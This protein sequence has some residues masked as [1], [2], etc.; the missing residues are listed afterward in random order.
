MYNVINDVRQI[1]FKVAIYIRLSKEDLDKV[2]S[3]DS[4][5]VSNQRNVLT[6][7]VNRNGYILVDEYI[8]D[9]YTGTNFNRPAFKRMIKDIED[10]KIDMVIT[11]DLSR[12]GRDYI[13]T[14]E[15]VEKYF[16]LHKI[17]LCYLHYKYY[18]QHHLLNLRLY[19]LHDM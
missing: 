8:D 10:K 15:Y 4:L 5:S 6:D 13:A 14:G 7:Y 16:P 18:Y 19:P 2:G 17:M 3:S 9:G 1:V 12:L 11:K